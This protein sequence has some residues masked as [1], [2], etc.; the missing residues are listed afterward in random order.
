MSAIVKHRYLGWTG[1]VAD[2][3]DLSAERW[4]V[5]FLNGKTV[6]VP[7]HTL[8]VIPSVWVAFG[9]LE[10]GTV[11]HVFIAERAKVWYGTGVEQGMFDPFAVGVDVMRTGAIS[12]CLEV[13]RNNGH[14]DARVDLDRSRSDM[15]DDDDEG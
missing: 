5:R 4:P 8:E 15:D 14:A 10:T 12:A 3:V 13:L 7:R 2:D 11:Y 9:D 1:T 6:E